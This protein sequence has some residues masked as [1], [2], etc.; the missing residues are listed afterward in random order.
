[1]EQQRGELED[2]GDNSETNKS[3]KILAF[4]G[5][6]GSHFCPKSFTSTTSL[7]MVPRETAS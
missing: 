6:P 7:V 1:M 4:G 2:T 3:E 5:N